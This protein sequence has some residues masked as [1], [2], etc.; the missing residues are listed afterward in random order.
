MLV[1]GRACAQHVQCPGFGLLHCI[2]I[3]VN[4]PMTQLHFT[5]S[6][7][8]GNSLKNLI[9]SYYLL[10]CFS[11]CIKIHLLIYICECLASILSLFENF[12]FFLP[13]EFFL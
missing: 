6:T 10:D 4:K 12:Q 7:K 8:Q 13:C 9:D 11:I 1:S 5:I 3:Q 2:N